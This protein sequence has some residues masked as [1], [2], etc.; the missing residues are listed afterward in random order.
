MQQKI[1]SDNITASAKGCLI[2]VHGKLQGTSLPIHAGHNEVGR[3]KGD[4]LLPEDAKVSRK[5]HCVI[6][7]DETK[8]EFSV[9]TRMLHTVK[10]N[11]ELISKSRLLKDRDELCIGKTYLIFRT[12]KGIERERW[13]EERQRLLRDLEPGAVLYGCPN[14]D[15]IEFSKLLDRKRIEVIDYD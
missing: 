13:L 10:V 1:N 11:G 15:M 7:Y 12:Q 8:D 14:A 6:N 5:R 9:R 3:V 4:I 2:Y